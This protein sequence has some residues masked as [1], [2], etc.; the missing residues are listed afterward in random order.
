MS[1]IQRITLISDPTN[2]FPKNAKNSFMVRLPERLTLPGD[3]WHASL[4][5]MSVPDHGQRNGVITTDPHTKV[6]TFS[7]TYLTR[8]YINGDYRRI[9]FLKKD[10]SVE[11]EDIMSAKHPVTSGSLFWK[12]LMQEVYNTI[13]VKL[14]YEQD[15]SKTFDVDERPI[16]SVK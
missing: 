15:Y 3:R 11:L 16:V 10:Y 5:S 14:M 6:D 13:M 8:K 7:M 12:R 1:N 4:L 9:S 2:E